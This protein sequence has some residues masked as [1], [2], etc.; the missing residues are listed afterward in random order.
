MTGTEIVHLPYRG[1]ATAITDLMSGQ[2]QL[3]FESLSSI[4][5]FAKSGEVR[6]LAVSGAKRSPAFPELPTIAEAG[7]P[8]YDAPTWSGVI[9]P[10]GIPRPI[11]DRLNTAINRAISTPMFKQRFEAIGDEPAGGSPED[12]AQLIARESTKWADV[13]KRSGTKLD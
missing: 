2:V 9:G 12:F 13:I 7:V 11:V 4:S 5:P 1:G 10:A 8:G 6:P 3:M